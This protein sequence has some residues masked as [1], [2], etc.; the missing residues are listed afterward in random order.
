MRSRALLLLV[1]LAVIAMASTGASAQDVPTIFLYVNDHTVGGTL[2]YDEIAEIEAICLEVDART[3]AEIAI[4][5]VNTTQPVGIDTFAVEVFE[6]NG[7]GKVN[8][9]NGVLL[10]VATDEG[11]WRIEVGYGLE[12]I[13]NDAKVGRIGRETLSPNLT[14]GDVYSGIYGAT[15]AVGQEIVDTYDGGNPG[16]DPQLF[17]IDWG[18]VAIAVAVFVGVAILTKG[19]AVIWLGNFWKRGGF[20]GGRSGGGGARGRF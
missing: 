12:G 10:V 5:L 4:L 13:L 17:V 3:G 20:G 7:I 1:A 9:D 6:A 19:R 16:R 14:A 15:L 2:F 8:L 18:A 11:D